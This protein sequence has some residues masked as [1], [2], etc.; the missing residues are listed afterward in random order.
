[1]SKGNKLQAPKGAHPEL[2]F[3][4]QRDEARTSLYNTLLPDA[5][6]TLHN[7]FLDAHASKET[8][9]KAALAILDRTGFPGETPVA[10]QPSGIQMN[11]PSDYLKN[12]LVGIKILT[13]SE[14]NLHET[15]EANQTAQET[16]KAQASIEPASV[17]RRGAALRPLLNPDLSSQPNPDVL[18][19][20]DPP[21]ESEEPRALDLGGSDSPSRENVHRSPS[22]G[23]ATLF[24]PPQPPLAAPERTS[25]DKSKRSE[26]A[27]EEG[28]S[29]SPP[30]RPAK[31]PNYF[32]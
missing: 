30:S 7:L 20:S 27:R 18:P 14:T 23:R 1:M 11:I 25:N 8:K 3:R 21:S 12:A 24:S 19:P 6:S 9:S 5:L 26:S 32:E 28:T 17:A 15:L 16:S 13:G 4:A 22:E 2:D 10:R 31:P 29:S